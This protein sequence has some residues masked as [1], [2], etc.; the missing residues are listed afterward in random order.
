[1]EK[2]QTLN[3]E[4]CLL[5][6]GRIEKG[7]R[8]PDVSVEY[9][10]DLF[11]ISYDGRTDTHYPKTMS[12]YTLEDT[13]KDFLYSQNEEER[14]QLDEYDLYMTKLTGV[15]QFSTFAPLLYEIKGVIK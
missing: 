11:S 14:R 3:G 10:F 12:L 8:T 13:I 6:I 2:V 7:K 15:E 4:R 5:Y 1:M 9:L